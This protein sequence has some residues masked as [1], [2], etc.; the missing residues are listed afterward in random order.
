[1]DGSPHDAGGDGCRRSVLEVSLSSPL[2]R[3][4]GLNSHPQ[5]WRYVNCF[6]IHAAFIDRR[7]EA[8]HA[9]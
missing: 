4:I 1:V 7:L 9:L 6:A 2:G 8:L 5:V 3:N